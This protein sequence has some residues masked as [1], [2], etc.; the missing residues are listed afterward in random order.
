MSVSPKAWQLCKI[1]VRDTE[2]C[3][4]VGHSVLMAMLCS[5]TSQDGG[6]QTQVAAEHVEW[7]S[8]ACAAAELS[9]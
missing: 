7:G 4:P 2:Q 1:K 3:W 9:L 6:P 8:G 5:C